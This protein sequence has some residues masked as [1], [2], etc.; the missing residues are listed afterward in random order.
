MK[1]STIYRKIK[2]G[3]YVRLRRQLQTR[4]GTILAKGLIMLVQQKYGGL[5]LETIHD[6]PCPTCG[7]GEVK[8]IAKVEVDSVEWLPDYNPDEKA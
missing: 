3:D 7:I 1:A 8:S 4:G 5:H 2:V 6:K